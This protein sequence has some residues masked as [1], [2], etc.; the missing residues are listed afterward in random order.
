MDDLGKDAHVE[1]YR[2]MCLEGDVFENLCSLY[3][4]TAESLKI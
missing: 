4:Q 1:E 2:V 3:P